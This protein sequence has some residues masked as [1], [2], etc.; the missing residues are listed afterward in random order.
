MEMTADALLEQIDHLADLVHS[1]T[2]SSARLG[3]ILGSWAWA[4]WRTPLTR[5]SLSLSASC[6][7]GWF[8]P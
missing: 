5:Q 2:Q 3:M 8:Q 4:R 6:R 7:V 1:R